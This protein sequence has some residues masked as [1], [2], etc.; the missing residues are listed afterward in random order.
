MDSSGYYQDNSGQK[1]LDHLAFS[2]FFFFFFLA[3]EILAG[4][5]SLMKVG[6]ITCLMGSWG[7]GSVIANQTSMLEMEIQSVPH[8]SLS[9]WDVF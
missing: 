7:L 2:V 8:F 3:L 5:T 6:V 4:W 1:H 9:T